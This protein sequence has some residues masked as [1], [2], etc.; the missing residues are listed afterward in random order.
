MA[1]VRDPAET[2]PN[3]TSQRIVQNHLRTSDRDVTSRLNYIVEQYGRRICLLADQQVLGSEM[4]G[5]DQVGGKE[6]TSSSGKVV[7][8]VRIACAKVFGAITEL[9]NKLD[10]LRAHPEKHSL[11]I[12]FEE[13]IQIIEKKLDTGNAQAQTR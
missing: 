10:E 3:A 11:G 7:V 4:L 6:V 9:Q 1:Y 2:L 12:S 8:V 13:E 5:A